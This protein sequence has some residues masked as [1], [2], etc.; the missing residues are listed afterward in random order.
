MKRKK[1]R[2]NIIAAG[3]I[4]I[5]S[6]FFL[7]GCGTSTA[8]KDFASYAKGVDEITLPEEVRIV[9][10]GEA[11]H[12][13]KE[14][15]ELRL[16]VF[17]H[18]VETTDVRAFVLEGDF[19]SCALTNDYIL[20][21]KGTAEEAVKNLGFDIYKTDEMLALVEWMHNYNQNVSENEKVRLYGIDM[22][23]NE[24]TLNRVEDFYH[25]VD[26]TKA[27]EYISK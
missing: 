25:T 21:D 10:L 15:Q 20:H 12:G 7:T 26:P 22:Q 16:D 8:I 9:A 4:M 23:Q 11:T 27:D 3:I 6:T 13:N 24:A 14:F 1:L 18:L 2:N 5:M 19:G 17:S